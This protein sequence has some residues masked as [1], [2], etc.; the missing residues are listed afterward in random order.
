MTNVRPVHVYVP[1]AGGVVSADPPPTLESFAANLYASLAPL[2]W[3]DD[4]VEWSLAKFSGAFG[5]M[6]QAV[7]DVAR[8]TPEG[9]GWSAVVDITRCPSGWLGWLA[10]FVGVSVSSRARGESS[11]R[12]HHVARQL[13]AR[14]ASRNSHRRATAFDGHQ[15]RAHSGTVGRRCIR[16]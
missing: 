13:Q 1:V 7:E 11:S 4:Q 15:D 9:P 5:E 12:V 16:T 6:F 8:D 14:H 2:A 10:Q 3:V